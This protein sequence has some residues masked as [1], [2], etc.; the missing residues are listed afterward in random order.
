VL[1]ALTQIPLIDAR[2]G[3]TAEIARVADDRMR[4]L[5]QGARRIYTPPLLALADH[6]SRDWLERCRNPYTAEIDE[7][8]AL[9]GSKGAHALNT[10]YEWF[11]TSGVCDDPDGGVRLLRVL[12]WRLKGLGK[13]LVVAW[14]S[15]P[16]GDF[17]NVTWPGFV[18]VITATAP[19][20]F[21][22][23]I[24]QPPITSF[25][26]TLPL[27]WIV[28]RVKMLR[29]DNIPPAHLLRRVFERCDGYHA[30]KR[31]LVETPICAPAFFALAGAKAGEGCI[32][33]RTQD[34]AAVREMP[35]AIAND[36]IALPERGHSRSRSSRDRQRMMEEALSGGK[37][38]Q[39]PPILNPD[40]RMVAV[41]N[42]AAG[43]LTAQGFERS[44]PATAPFVM[45]A[46]HRMETRLRAG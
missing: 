22:A 28:G 31:V 9:I 37:N 44:E 27:D 21:A 40:T 33:E 8:A 11:C 20:R 16:A 18:G 10:S 4:D 26:L 35:T 17:L 23:A 46:R 7:I 34:R 6:A 1:Q 13:N 36:W 12:D 42:P 32:I 15:G 38:W 25:G 30:A 5:L 2:R 24:N 19:G 29:S 41:M 14:Q 43:S 3:G 45:P 39:A